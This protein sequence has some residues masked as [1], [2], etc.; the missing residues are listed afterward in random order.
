ME[1]TRWTNPSQPQ[2]LQSSVILLYV[3]AAFSIL[4]GGFGGVVI[5]LA[6][7]RVAA[8]WGCAN[9]R[10]WGY[11]LAVAMAVLPFLVLF[12]VESLG[13]IADNLFR[14]LITFAFDIVLLALLLHRETRGYQRIWFR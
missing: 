4:F 9:E 7:G 11:Q 13:D 1:T 8:G 5:L 6:A 14:I 2:T 3:N 12:A 10:K